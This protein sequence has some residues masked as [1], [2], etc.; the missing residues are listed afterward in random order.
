MEHG[1]YFYIG[2]GFIIIGIIGM[3]YL[4]SCVQMTAWFQTFERLMKK[5][6]NKQ[7]KKTKKDEQKTKKK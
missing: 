4:L 7:S 6:Y 5:Q 2:I 3:V 1:I